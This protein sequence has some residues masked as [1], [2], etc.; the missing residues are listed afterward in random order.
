[1]VSR[2]ESSTALFGE[3]TRVFAALRALTKSHD[4]AGWD[5]GEAAPASYA[6]IGLAIAFVRA[7]PDDC[8][9]PEVGVD[10][11]GAISLDWLCTRH[12]MLSISF[13]GR[14]NRLAFA[15]LDGTDRGNGVVRFDR[16]MIPR[17]L[18]EAI[19]AVSIT[20]EYA[21]FRAS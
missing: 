15:W 9:L 17:R 18:V 5:G 19:A 4:Q 12:R 1:M 21:G 8:A 13:T 11:D 16:Q 10:P 20:G 14:S 3:R 6:A 7:L 2:V